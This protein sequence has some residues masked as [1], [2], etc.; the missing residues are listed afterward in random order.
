LLDE[1]D[2]QGYALA[3]GL[4][5]P[6]ECELIAANLP[7]DSASVGHRR[8]LDETWCAALAQRLQRHPALAAMIPASHVAVQC[9]WFEK[10]SDRNWLV[11][12]HQDLSIPVAAR[13]PE[14]SLRGWSEKEGQLY[15]QAPLPVLNQLIAVRLHL[16]PCLAGDGALKVVPGSHKL[17]RL[18]QVEA[19]QVRQARGEFECHSDTGGVLL[20]RPPLLHAS[21]KSTGNS[22]RRVLHF[23]F[24]PQA[25]PFGMEWGREFSP[26]QNCAVRNML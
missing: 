5:E 18:D 23:V 19:A 2:E 6:G 21:S 10:S 15:V 12:M 11:P 8:L 3:P 22:R 7:S 16:D 26:A 1:F 20:L 14:P 4:L 17:G 13:V 24:G 9:T 25:L